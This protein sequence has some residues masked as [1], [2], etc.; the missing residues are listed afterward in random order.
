MGVP[1]A[2]VITQIQAMIRSELNN[3]NSIQSA[4]ENVNNYLVAV[5]SPEKFAT[6]CFGIFDP[7]TQVFEYSNAGHNYPAVVRDD[8]SH[9]HL[10]VGGMVIGAFPGAIYEAASITLKTGDFI[11]FFTDGISETQNEMDEE[12]GEERLLEKL[13]GMRGQDAESII[14]GALDDVDMF[15]RVDPPQDDRTIV[16]LKTL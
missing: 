12:Y 16:V 2:M 5:T 1:A 9:E 11:F 3:C 7:K 15:Y 14:K 13:L 10:T 4:L 6:L 8:G